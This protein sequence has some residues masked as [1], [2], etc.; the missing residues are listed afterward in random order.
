MYNDVFN[1]TLKFW[2]NQ[3]SYVNNI[4]YIFVL[5]RKCIDIFLK[6]K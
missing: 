2:G 5:F 3:N 4:A 6:I 1:V